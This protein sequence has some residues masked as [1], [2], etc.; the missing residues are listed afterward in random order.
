RDRPTGELMVQKR[1][2]ELLRLTGRQALGARKP[3]EVVADLPQCALIRLDLVPQLAKIREDAE[4]G[5]QG[6]AVRKRTGGYVQRVDTELRRR[7]VSERRE[8]D[9]AVGVKLERFAVESCSY[10]RDER[11][12]AFRGEQ[13]RRVLDVDPA[14]VGRLRERGGQICVERIVVHG[15][16]RE[17]ET[18]ENLAAFLRDHARAFE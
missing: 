1:G 13:A 5:G 17:G 2:I 9:R 14:H 16:D 7:E 11:A 4:R 6:R 8:P 3:A 18:G 10:S 12:G 15:T